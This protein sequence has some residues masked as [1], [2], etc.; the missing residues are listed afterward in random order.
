MFFTQHDGSGIG[1]GFRG[2]DTDCM[3]PEVKIKSP[4]KAKLS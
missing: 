4:L 3:V 1:W 2:T